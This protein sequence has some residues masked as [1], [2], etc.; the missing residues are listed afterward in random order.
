MKLHRLSGCLGLLSHIAACAALAL[1]L[2]PSPVAAQMSL[3]R[4][5]GLATELDPTVTAKRQ[6]VASRTLGI[7]EARDAYYPS[8]NVSADSNT[9]DANGPG[10]TLTIS[11]VLYDWGLIRSQ[12]KSATQARV[13]SIS[14]LKMAVEA[15]TLDV[16]E[17][18]LDV[19]IADR[20]IALTN[21][22]A[23]YAGRLARQAEDRARAGLG[24][25]GEVA[26][27]RLEI[28]RAEDR[29][30]T[31]R[32]DRALSLSQIGFLTG[33]DPRGVAAPPSLGYA[34]RYGSMEQIRQAVR[35]APDYVASQASAAE[36]E[37]EVQR[38]KAARLPT[39]SLQAEGRTDLNGGR[40][41]TAL[42]IAAGVDLN[43]S[44]V[45]GRSLQISQRDFAAAKYNLQGVERQLINV[46]Q[47]SL[48]QLNALRATEAAR[49]G[50]LEESRRV[51]DTYEE[52]FTA[53]QRDL[54]D[55][56]TTGRD[57]YDAQIEQ[58]ETYEDRKRTEY[59]AAHDL[60]VLGTLILE[61][62][63]T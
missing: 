40:T 30:A 3:T 31:L 63:R 19:E 28:A 38:T 45:G 8:V 50:Q 6:V 57:L 62:S 4:A 7:Q 16:A 49:A 13:R 18:F 61:A 10:I 33:R 21:E 56:L 41:R 9:T 15:L 11:Q 39:I 32:S 53:G 20:K 2:A 48:Q 44:T 37:A 47:T 23:D 35:I 58:V 52:Q 24:D 54:I 17:A 1:C 27:A 34:R 46:A 55:V 43:A 59:E 22:Y 29:L 14:D 51:L 12:I 36:A 60:G 5:L 42:G 25:N 26:R